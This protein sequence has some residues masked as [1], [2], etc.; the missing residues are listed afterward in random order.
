MKPFLVL[1]VLVWTA[2]IRAESPVALPFSG[3]TWQLSGD[4]KI[5][6]YLG[7]PALRAR[8]GGAVAP[9]V[10]FRDGT[11]DLEMATGTHRNF[12]MVYLRRQGDGEYEEFYFRTHHSELPDAVQYTPAWQGVGGWQLFHGPGFT[13]PASF[14]RD[15]WI[16]IR[17][18][19]SGDRAAVFVG[20]KDRPQL[21]SRLRREPKAGTVGLGGLLL[22]DLPPEASTSFSNV[23][24]RPGDVP[25]DFSTASIVERRPAGVVERWGV[26]PFPPSA[27]ERVVRVLPAVSAWQTLPAEPSGLLVAERYLKRPEHG[28][29]AGALARVFVDSAS[30]RVAEF[31]FGYSDEVTVFLDG[32]PLF[33]GDASYSVDDPRQEGLVGLHQGLVYL[34]LHPGRN[35]LV[36]AVTDS[37]GGWGWIGQLADS[38]GLRIFP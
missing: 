18:V 29:R 13:A 23:V 25:F 12:S 5:E 10:S 26:S 36:L 37:F 28:A 19:L 8:N 24:L 9:G 27:Q 15:Q 38:T 1:P 17:I 7:R 33:S 3:A 20:T 2:A 14:P 4:A 32:K 21:V 22:G 6:T 11:I 34:R 31:R 35:E 16:P 30:A